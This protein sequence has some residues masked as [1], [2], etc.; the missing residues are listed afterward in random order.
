[1]WFDAQTLYPLYYVSYDADGEEI[2]V[3][4]FVGRWSEDRPDYPRWPDAP[5]RPVRVIDPVGEG[6][7]NLRLEGSWR[8]ESWDVVSVPES[9]REVARSVSIRSIQRGR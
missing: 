5:E 3:G 6:F 9:D 1:M 4:Y 7:A 2:D 8:R